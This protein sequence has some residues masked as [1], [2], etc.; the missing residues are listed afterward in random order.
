MGCHTK[1]IVQW[2]E[3]LAPPE[4]AEEWD[5]IGLQIG[6]LDRPVQRVLLTLTVTPSVVQQAER[7]AIDLIVAHHPI[8]FRP[9]VEL[10]WDRPTGALIRHL[11]KANID[12]Y[13]AHTN[14]DAARAGTSHIMAQRLGLTNQ[15]ALVPA[16]DEPAALLGFGRVGDLETPV[17]PQTF[18]KNIGRAFGLSNLR[19][20]GLMPQS[21]RRVAVMGGAGASFMSNA[22]AAGADAYVTGDIKF[23]D[24]LD[25]QD[26]GLWVIDAGHFAT[27][28]ISMAYWKEYLD[29]QAQ[30]AGFG[31]ETFV[32]NEEDPFRYS[33]V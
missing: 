20:N 32:A 14:F 33:T 26:L 30:E 4:L 25:A 1:H 24:A 19:H 5:R 15:R 12:V 23:H 6:A 7:L 31:L 27:E 2:M 3:E 11:T 9:L 29:R 10:R 8:I 21:V 17:L 16:T 22:A 13:A 28:R 18:L